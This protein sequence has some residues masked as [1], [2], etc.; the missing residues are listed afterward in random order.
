[1]R[2]AE[3]KKQLT[4]KLKKL[5]DRLDMVMK[6]QLAVALKINLKT[7]E[8]YMSGDQEEVRR[9]ELAEQIMD[10]AEILLLAKKA[11]A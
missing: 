9:L 2:L 1:M 4:D 3:F 8:R 7:V 6:M 10:Q 5:G 11:V